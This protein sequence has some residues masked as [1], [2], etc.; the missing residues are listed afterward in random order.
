MPYEGDYTLIGTTDM[1]VKGGVSGIQI[2]QEETDYL[3]KS[4]NQYFQR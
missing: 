3:L 1:E 2:T 4:V